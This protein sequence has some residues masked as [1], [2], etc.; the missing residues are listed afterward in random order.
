MN[1]ADES[2]SL[3]IRPDVSPASVTPGPRR[4]LSG[5]VA[6][7]LSLARESAVETVDLDALVHAGKRLYRGE[8]KTE[9]D[10]KAFG[11]FLRAAEG[12]HSEAQYLV[13]RCYHW[14]HGV[15]LDEDLAL[16]WLRRS[17]E[18]GFAEAQYWLGNAYSY[19]DGVPQDYA[20]A[21]KWYRKAAE[22]GN[23]DAQEILGYRY[24]VGQGVPQDDVEAAKWFRRAAEQGNGTA[25]S[26]LGDCY[27]EGSGVPVD[28]VQAYKW[29]RLA[30]DEGH[31]VEDAQ[32]VA[33]LMSPSELQAAQRLY[34]E[35][36]GNR[37]AKH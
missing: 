1:E 15:Q 22:Q 17:A 12:G 4:I 5:M 19:G 2:R 28:I 8:G 24:Y 3:V 36:K 26:T 11:L 34:H 37:A 21:A 23:P 35:F 25:Q 7:A 31:T 20:E 32:K 14:E 6:E 18:A 30:E 16:D 27:L 9:E 29:F 13:S 10:I 33:A